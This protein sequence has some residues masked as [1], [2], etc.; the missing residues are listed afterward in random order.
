MLLQDNAATF[1]VAHAQPGENHTAKF[2]DKFVYKTSEFGGMSAEFKATNNGNIAFN[3]DFTGLFKVRLKS[4]S[5]LTYFYLSFRTS[6]DLRNLLLL[7]KETSV[8]LKDSIGK[9]DSNTMVKIISSML[10]LKLNL[11]QLSPPKPSG[12]HAT[13]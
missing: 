13:G 11:P 5:Y 1:K 8:P 7:L 9:L 3:S 6:K 12:D 2:E 4:T 10:N